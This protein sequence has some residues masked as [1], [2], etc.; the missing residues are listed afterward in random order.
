[1]FHDAHQGRGITELLANLNHLNKLTSQLEY[2][3]RAIAGDGTVRVTYTASGRPTAAII[4]DN[5]AVLES[6]LY[7]TICRSRDEAYFLLATLNSQTLEENTGIFMPK[8]LFGAR[9]F[10]KH[11]WKL[12]IP[13][14]DAGD[15]LHVRLSELGA[16][17]E[18][19]CQALIA[20]SDIMSR[21]AGDAQSRAARRLL[22]HTWQPESETARAIE[23]AVT[24]L[25]SEPGQ[26]ALAVRQMQASKGG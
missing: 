16:T 14:Y 25:L 18:E 12:P 26:A 6:N 22:R 19:E 17:A 7:Q 11:G 21:P 9:H 1:M 10:Q 13:R 8:G 20:A 4:Q 24:R 23:S 2:L 15:A 5:H 3:Q